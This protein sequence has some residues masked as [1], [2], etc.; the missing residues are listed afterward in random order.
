MGG[1]AHKTMSQ[2]G[3]AARTPPFPSH[4]DYV[5][6]AYRCT[7]R[8]SYD[9][10]HEV[11]E[12]SAHGF[13]T[14]SNRRELCRQTGFQRDSPQGTPY[15]CLMDDHAGTS[16][17][18]TA[19]T[20]LRATWAALENTRG[21]T[22]QHTAVW[23]RGDVR[24]TCSGFIGNLQV[25]T[26]LQHACTCTCTWNNVTGYAAS[27]MALRCQCET[28]WADSPVPLSG[29]PSTCTDVGEDALWARPA[30]EL[31]LYYG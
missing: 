24:T 12:S 9:H 28:A 13:T 14:I 26:K 11:W 21:S 8:A 22:T 27:G 7:G 2:H 16:N 19:K 18:T 20:I 3:V 15:V 23:W 1:H 29:T 10:F 25:Q 31:E 5:Q 30:D 6:A 4:L 17:D